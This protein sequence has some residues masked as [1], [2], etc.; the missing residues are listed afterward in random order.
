VGLDGNDTLTGGAGADVM[1]GGLGNDTYVVD[2]AGDLVLEMA[3]GGTDTVKSSITHTLSS[4]VENLTLT[5]TRVINGTGNALD[6]TLVGNSA[7]NF[8]DGALGVDDLFGGAGNDI[9]RFLAGETAGDTVR[10]FFGNGASAGDSLRLVGFGAGAVLTQVDA[11]D[12]W[13]ISYN[14]GNGSEL[15]HLVGVTTLHSSDY[16]FV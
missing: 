1:E 10:D 7:A 6:N 14:G 9:F 3:G 12:D 11:S 8:L 15:L 4:D 5:A 13:L 16:A 2:S